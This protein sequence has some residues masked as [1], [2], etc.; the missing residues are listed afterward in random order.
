ML[1]RI[2]VYM[3]F[4][5]KIDYLMHVA[6]PNTFLRYTTAIIGALVAGKFA[7]ANITKSLVKKTARIIGYSTLA[8]TVLSAGVHVVVHVVLNAYLDQDDFANYRD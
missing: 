4:F 3:S 2:N 6:I 8:L 1:K 5:E 7:Y